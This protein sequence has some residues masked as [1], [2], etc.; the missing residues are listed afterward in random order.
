MSAVRGKKPNNSPLDP[1]I[2]FE[3]LLSPHSSV[4]C[5]LYRIYIEDIPYYSHVHLIRHK[6]GVE[7]TVYS[8]RVLAG[9]DKFTQDSLISMHMDIN[10][11]A[12]LNIAKVR[13]CNKA[14]KEIRILMTL[15]KESLSKGDKYDQVLGKLMMPNCELYDG[16]CPEPRCC[17]KPGVK[18][19]GNLHRE[20]VK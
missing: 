10:A 12:L 2:W 17:G 15:I 5:I 9:R 16:I 20:R 18:K 4:R 7:P 11:Q 14:D 1:N 6:I 8:Q 19:L 3:M 13:L